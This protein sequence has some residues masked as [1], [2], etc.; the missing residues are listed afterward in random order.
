MKLNHESVDNYSRLT[1]MYESILPIHLNLE[2]PIENWYRFPIGYVLD[3]LST[4][5]IKVQIG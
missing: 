4:E 3:P 1:P 5:S 2:N